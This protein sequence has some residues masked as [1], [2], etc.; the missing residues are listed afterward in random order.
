MSRLVVAVFVPTVIKGI[1]VEFVTKTFQLIATDCEK[2]A[3]D[4]GLP[5]SSAVAARGR[6]QAS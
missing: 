3:A 5:A 1:T 2:K 6:L 4:D